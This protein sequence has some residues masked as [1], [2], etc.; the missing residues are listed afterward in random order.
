MHLDQLP[1]CVNQISRKITCHSS[2]FLKESSSQMRE[3]RQKIPGARV[4]TP[5]LSEM[6]GVFI[7][8]HNSAVCLPVVSDSQRFI[9]VHS[10]QI[11]LQMDGAAELDKAFD[12]FPYLTQK[13]TAALAQRCSLHPDQVKVWFMVQ[14]LRY[15]ISWD[16]NDICEVWRKFKSAQRTAEV[17]NRMREEVKEDTGENE[18]CKREV[19]E[20]GGKKTGGV[21]EE[22]SADEG[23]RMG[24]K[25]KATKRLE[26][27]IKQEQQMEKERDREAEEERRNAQRKRQ[28]V[29]ATYKMRKKRVKQ[30]DEGVVGGAGEVE[31]SCDEDERESGTST[32]LETPLSTRKEMTAKAN[33]RLQSIQEW[34]ADKSFVVPDEPLDTSPL[35]TPLSQTQACNGPPLADNRTTDT[36]MTAVKSGSEGETEKEAVAADGCSPIYSNTKTRAQLAMMKV[37]FLRCQYPDRE[38]YNRLSMLIGAPRHMLVQWFGDMRYHIKKRKPRWMNKEQHKQALANIRYRQCLNTLAKAQLG[39][40]GRKSTWKIVQVPPD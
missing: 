30:W 25:V 26:K 27:K 15:G 11:N 31:I 17:Q 37:A 4:E 33:S 5:T 16:Y 39:D 3:I 32:Q 36:R 18:K 6:N 1:A 20:P 28:L 29:T 35:L 8:N 13:Q 38:E 10:N 12:R 9:W 24:E 14:R 2:Y 7:L 19:K 21:R 40:A 23:R 22:Q 34:P